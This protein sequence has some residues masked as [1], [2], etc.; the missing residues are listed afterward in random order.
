LTGR[1]STR[2]PGKKAA[3][4]IDHRGQA[5]LTLPL[6]KPS[7]ILP[8]FHGNFQIDATPARRLAFR[9]TAW[10]H[11]SVF[12]RLDCDRDEIACFTSISPLLS[13]KLFNSAFK[14]FGLQVRH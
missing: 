5:P 11:H 7:T 6:T 13:K 8:S 14:L 12:Q 9:V 10:F 4:D 3:D 2:E 1:I